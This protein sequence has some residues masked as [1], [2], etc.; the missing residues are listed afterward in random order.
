[1]KIYCINLE[2]SKERRRNMQAQFDKLSL[3]VEFIN[4][5]DGRALSNGEVAEVYSKWRT[6][7]CSGKGLSR[8]EI[9]C[10]LSHIEFYKRVI[11]D[12]SPGF[13]FEDDVELG[14]EVK[15]ALAKIELFLSNAKAPCLIQLPGLNRDMPQ[16]AEGDIVK[17]SIAMGTYAYGVNPAAAELLLKSF[18]PIKFPIDYY[19]HLIKHYGLN[20][21]VFIDKTISVDMVS[22]STVGMDR[23]KTYKGIGLMCYKLWR[24]IGKTIDGILTGMNL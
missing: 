5:I 20:F 15:N 11:A 4:A 8:G 21:Y 12:N 13:V 17:V 16:N 1:M 6:R 22:E 3:P 23:F 14:G 18:S 19:G 7:F 10:A 2:R 9:G 24:L